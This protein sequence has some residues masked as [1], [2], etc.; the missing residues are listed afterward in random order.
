MARMVGVLKRSA[1][2]VGIGVG[3]VVA[4]GGAVWLGMSLPTRAGGPTPDHAAEPSAGDA[5]ERLRRLDKDS[6]SAP[7]SLLK[8]VGVETMP[9]TK[10]TRS[11]ALPALQGVLNT[12]SNRLV[13]VNSPFPGK[14][15]AV[16]PCYACDTAGAA[17]GSAA[18]QFRP[19]RQG[20]AVV[21]DQ[22]LAVVWS[23]QLGEKKSEL[24]D[25][26]SKLGRDE[27]VLKALKASGAA[28]PVMISNAN[29]DV[30]SDVI[31][32]RKAEDTLRVWQVSEEEIAAVRAEAAALASTEVGVRNSTNWA[33]VEIRA[34]Q[35]GVILEKNINPG[36]VVDSTTDLFKVGD[37]SQLTVWVHVYE[38][39]LPVL[40]GLPKP[41]RWKVAVPSR[42][43]IALEGTVDQISPVID[44]NQHTA[45]VT[46][47]V[48]NPGGTLQAGLFVTATVEIKPPQ[49]EVEIPS[50]AVVE[51]GPESVVLVQ[52]PADPTVFRRKTVRV[53]RR[54]RDVV[55][56]RTEPD[57]VRIGDRVV[58][59][60]AL[61]LN[62]A[63]EQIPGK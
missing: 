42:P 40:E 47:R 45:L 35:D 31:A 49:D 20:D 56:A 53:T 57:G 30:Q 60:G 18:A 7:E 1:R 54:F 9:V 55:Y 21:K 2:H 10:P 33:R 61:L 5:P 8:R 39:D 34:P 38:E 16:G 59:S 44:P 26:L 27:E 58:T 36:T 62:E 4:A 23:S 32:V 19:L 48:G 25:A 50:A 22:L 24:V 6:V 14:V 29:R 43:T 28:P 11:R 17:V 13:R 51:G 15:I 52:D 46:G 63:A 3:L 41:I 12:D 37:L